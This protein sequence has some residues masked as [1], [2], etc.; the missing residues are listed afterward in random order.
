METLLT[1]KRC[2]PRDEIEKKVFFYKPN[3]KKVFSKK[4]KKHFQTQVPEVHVC[5]EQFRN[6]LSISTQIDRL[7]VYSI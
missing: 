1:N 5:T 2:E 6:R 7:N 4:K 3:K